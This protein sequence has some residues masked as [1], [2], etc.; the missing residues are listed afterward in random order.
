MLRD[1]SATKDDIAE[2][3]A[4]LQKLTDEVTEYQYYLTND[5]RRFLFG[6][7]LSMTN[8]PQG[9]TPQQQRKTLPCGNTC[10]T[11]T[12]TGTGSTSLTQDSFEM[13]VSTS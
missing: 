2:A 8:E 12:I 9:S 11:E 13:V 1:S 4:G 7:Y 5:P 3:R 10:G 6:K